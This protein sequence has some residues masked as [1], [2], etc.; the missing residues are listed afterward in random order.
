[1]KSKDL[2]LILAFFAISGLRFVFELPAEL[3]ANWAPRVI[4]NHEKHEAVAVARK[5][6]LSVA[7]PW[8]L[9][10]AL[11]VYIWFSLAPCPGRPGRSY[12]LELL[13]GRSLLRGFRKIAFT[14]AHAPW[15]Q[16]ATVMKSFFMRWVLLSLR[17][18]LPAWN[19]LYCSTAQSIYG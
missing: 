13:P 3:R 5:V 6:M 17:P 8:L 2:P 14:C 18:A 11:P 12:G 1:L 10:I 7:W 19:T 15:K 4:L 16:N 9:L